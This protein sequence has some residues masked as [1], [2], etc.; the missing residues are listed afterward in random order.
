MIQETWD[1][2]TNTAA[3]L[4][5]FLSPT[6]NSSTHTSKEIFSESDFSS[7]VCAF[8]QQTPTHYQLPALLRLHPLDSKNMPTH[9]GITVPL[10]RPFRVKKNP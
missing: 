6:N 3:A 4:K 7:L 9:S 5:K 10:V 1:F 2:K 8:Y